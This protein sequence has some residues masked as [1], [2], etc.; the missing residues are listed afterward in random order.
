MIIFEAMSFVVPKMAKSIE[1]IRKCL[2]SYGIGC[3]SRQGKKIW[4]LILIF[5]LTHKEL[6]FNM[7]I[8]P[9]RKYC[10]LLFM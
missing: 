4:I 10:F 6:I 5:L 9:V 1:P 7:L 3:S 2:Q 8:N